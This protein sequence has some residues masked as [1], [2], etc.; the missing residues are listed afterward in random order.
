[1]RLL[2][3]G[4]V[5]LALAAVA[6]AWCA[7]APYGPQ[8]ETFVDLPAGTPT[9]GIGE[10]LADA[11]VVRSAVC[12]DLLRPLLRGTLKAGEYRFDHPATMVEVYRRIERGDVYTRTLVVP[13]GYNIY[14]IAAA[15]QAA[16][17]GTSAGFLQAART[18]VALVR[19]W[20]PT[21]ESAE[22]FLFPDTYRFSRHTSDAQMVA[23]M[24]ERFEV[25]ARQLGLTQSVGATV[26]MASLVEKE[27][28]VAAERPLVA[29]VFTNR[30]AKKMPLQTDP[31]VIYAALREGRYRGTI[32][33]SDLASESPYNTY[34]HAGLPPGPICNP[35]AASL[36]AAMQPAK[37]DYL[38]F[39]S[40]AAGH[41]RF[42]TGLAEHAKKVTAYRR[43]SETRRRH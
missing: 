9:T 23:A 38:Y 41:S 27:T 26:T 33:A 34:R 37:T 4:L 12:F 39:V 17:L 29:G 31:S 32:Y 36:L 8:T 14:D 5:V 24:V 18:G 22:G 30:L 13:E 16:G 15:A 11:G 6:A 1:L 40:D 2:K 7:L 28:G 21:A 19:G 25:V 20:Q 35:G 3:L 10:A 43:A 42:S